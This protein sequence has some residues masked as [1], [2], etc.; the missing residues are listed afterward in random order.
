MNHSRGG[1]QTGGQ[2][3]QHKPGKATIEV[4]N[5]YSHRTA[6]DRSGDRSQ[7]RN[8]LFFFEMMQKQRADYRVEWA[9]QGLG[10][11]IVDEELNGS[12]GLDCSRPSIFNGDGA[13]VAPRDLP[14]QSDGRSSPPKSNG[15]VAGPRGDVENAQPALSQS[16]LKFDEWIEKDGAAATEEI[17]PRQPGQGMCVTS[18]IKVGLVHHFC[19]A[20]SLS[21]QIHE[22]KSLRRNL[23]NYAERARRPD[24]TL[25]VLW[26]I[27][28]D[29]AGSTAERGVE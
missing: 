23:A 3:R 8:G 11:R 13:D 25:S 22:E 2:V 26:R 18:S 21:K 29:A 28:L 7:E 12:A 5:Q 9:R 16:L 27:G 6:V 24:G 15:Y 14:V 10:Q 20:V 19:F 4:V 1:Q 17:Q